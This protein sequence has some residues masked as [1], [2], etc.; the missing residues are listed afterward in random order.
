MQYCFSPLVS[1]D[2]TLVGFGPVK[3]LEKVDG[4][5][6]RA[7]VDCAS[8]DITEKNGDGDLVLRNSPAIV[9]AKGGDGD[10]L[11]SG[12]APQVGKNY[13]GAGKVMPEGMV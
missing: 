11:Y 2:K 12:P 1:G 3:V 5:G 10:I 9:R 8:V 6:S 7:F 13:G 4:Y